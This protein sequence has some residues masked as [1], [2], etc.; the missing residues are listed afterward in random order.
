MKTLS[1]QWLARLRFC[2]ILFVN[3]LHHP[4]PCDSQL[5]SSITLSSAQ[6]V[7]GRRRIAK[8]TRG[9]SRNTWLDGIQIKYLQLEST[10]VFPKRQEQ[11]IALRLQKRK[12]GGSR[13]KQI[14][15]V[16][17]MQ[18]PR[19]VMTTIIR[20]SS[21]E[22]ARLHGVRI[23]AVPA[24]YMSEPAKCRESLYLQTKRGPPRE[25]WTLR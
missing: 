3:L 21:E 14:R 8:T 2:R 18:S 12:N 20:V 19:T 23:D 13:S 7:N 25:A 11:T 4:Q 6:S 24:I 10:L 9:P 22:Q 15:N 5:P 1:I 17:S 16:K